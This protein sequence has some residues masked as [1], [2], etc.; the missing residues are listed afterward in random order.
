MRFFP[1]LFHIG[2]Y[3]KEEVFPPP[4]FLEG[5]FSVVAKNWEINTF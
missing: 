2:L 1:L 4:G 5:V 3:E